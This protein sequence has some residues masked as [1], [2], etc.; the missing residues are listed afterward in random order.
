[1][2]EQQAKLAERYF[3]EEISLRKYGT[4]SYNTEEKKEI[5]KNFEE[6]ERAVLF[7]EESLKKSQDMT[8][9]MVAF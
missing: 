8:Q 1:M 9:K 4:R 2:D 6:D 5:E 3:R 7:I